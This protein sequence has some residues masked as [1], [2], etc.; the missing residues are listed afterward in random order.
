MK[1]KIRFAQ[2]LNAIVTFYDEID[3]KIVIR[4]TSQDTGLDID[5]VQKIF[6]QAET[7]WK[8]SV[9]KDEK[10]CKRCGKRWCGRRQ[11]MEM[12]PRYFGTKKCRDK[13]PRR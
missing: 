6:D 7:T 5:H 11:L 1:K 10:K 9:F 12:E 3:L 4:G 2:M 8:K 13:G